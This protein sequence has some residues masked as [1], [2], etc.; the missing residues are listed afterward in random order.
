MRFNNKFTALLRSHPY[1]RPFESRS[2]SQKSEA[3][4][5]LHQLTTHLSC[6]DPQQLY[7]YF[8]QHS[9]I[10][11][12][13]LPEIRHAVKAREVLENIKAMHAAAP[14]RHKSNVLALVAN[15]YTRRDLTEGGFRFSS[16][17]YCTAKR[18]AD[19]GILSLSDYPRH[20]PPSRSAINQQTKALVVDYL[21]RNSRI[22]SARGGHGSA[23]SLEP[24][25]F[26]E[27]PKRDIYRQLMAENP[28]TKLS[29]SKFYN[30]S[31]PN[32]KKAQKKTD[33][34]EVCVSGEKLM[35]KLGSL[36]STTVPAVIEGM[37]HQVELYR[38][39]VY[40]KDQ[41]LKYYKQSIEH[42][43]ATSCVIIMD[44]KENFKIG[45]GPVETSRNFF[46]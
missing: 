13:L 30:L 9:R 23:D 15:T 16:T 45:G 3:V 27:K 24:T 4:R 26:L 39:H 29:L 20:V 40:F 5:L 2:P 17:Q 32:F 19:S 44:F 33:M 22:S 36:P 43:T 46:E 21:R 41:Q 1:S 12:S 11:N 7:N 34:C 6:G 18:K 31:P 37:R 28:D 42:T 35:R 10:A 8:F 25:Y 14:T 38:Q